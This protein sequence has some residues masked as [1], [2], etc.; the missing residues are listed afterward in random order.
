MKDMNQILIAPAAIFAIALVWLAFSRL[1]VKQPGPINAGEV[2]ILG[3]LSI[4]PTARA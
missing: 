2:A 3:S 1:K 4:V